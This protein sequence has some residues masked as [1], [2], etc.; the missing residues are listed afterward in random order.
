MLQ[1]NLSS[2]VKNNPN[3][4]FNNNSLSNKSTNKILQDKI[5]QKANKRVSL[6]L[7]KGE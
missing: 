1:D 5:L 7:V 3:Q 6:D 2:K 4:S